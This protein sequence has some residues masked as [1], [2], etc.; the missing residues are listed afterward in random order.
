MLISSAH[1]LMSSAQ[2]TVLLYTVYMSCMTA[3]YCIVS[4]SAH[5]HCILT[6]LNNSS[7]VVVVSIQCARRARNCILHCTTEY[8]T[9][10]ILHQAHE[11]DQLVRTATWHIMSVVLPLASV[12]ACSCTVYSSTVLSSTVYA[13]AGRDVTTTMKA[14]CSMCS[15][16]VCTCI[17]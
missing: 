6:T 10:V 13:V 3:I 8:C 16:A 11:V 17:Q 9:T 15:H 14:V 4:S 1:Q 7:L 2:L 12:Q 5:A